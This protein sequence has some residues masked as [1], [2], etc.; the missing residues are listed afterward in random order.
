M[1]RT[2]LGVI[3]ELGRAA[4]VGEHGEQPV[5][6]EHAPHGIAAAPRGVGLEMGGEVPGSPRPFPVP[7]AQL[8]V[9]FRAHAKPRP[10]VLL[11]DEEGHVVLGDVDRCGQPRL[12]QE[13]RH[14]PVDRRDAQCGRDH[15]R[16]HAA[17]RARTHGRQVREA[18]DQGATAHAPDGLGEFGRQAG[19]FAIVESHVSAVG[20]QV[21]G[22]GPA[23]T[24]GA[25]RNN[26][27]LSFQL[28]FSSRFQVSVDSSQR[29][30]YW[31]LSADK[32]CGALANA[33]AQSRQAVA[34][35]FSSCSPPFHFV[36]QRDHQSGA[37]AAQGMPQGHSSSV[38]VRL[39]LVEPQF[40]DAGQRLHGKCLIQ[41]NQVNVADG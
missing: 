8:L 3:G 6:H 20:C 35:L 17:Q 39:G 41:L 29:Y 16:H 11:T 10:P 28:H 22:N 19:A 23:N 25:T 1:R 21:Q 12:P 33:D 2:H 5:L 40:L 7:D 24:P 34:H 31:L 38:D 26:R 27:D 32:S 13:A 9:P 14:E 30:Q 18:R 15:Q 37:G 36:Q 4:H